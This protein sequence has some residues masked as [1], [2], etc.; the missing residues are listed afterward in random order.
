MICTDNELY[1]TDNVDPE[2][3]LVH[4]K[5]WVEYFM[6]RG[7]GGSG[8]HDINSYFQNPNDTTDPIYLQK[9]LHFINESLPKVTRSILKRKYSGGTPNQFELAKNVLVSVA[10]FLASVITLELEVRY[11]REPL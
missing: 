3:D 5:T 7:F 6:V 2:K 9:R 11:Y 8:L 4:F 1:N 10:K